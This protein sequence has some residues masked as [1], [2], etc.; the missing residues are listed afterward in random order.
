ML[1]Q[2]IIR[3]KR[4]GEA[5]SREAIDAFVA[6]VVD[7]RASDAQ[8]AAF[9]MAVLLKRMTLDERV[10]LTEAMTRS[11][12]VLDWHAAGFDGPVLDKHSTGGVGDT[13]SLILAPAIA[14]CGAIVP[15]VSGRGLGHTG[16]TLD[17]LESIPGYHAL[18]DGDHLAA[19]LRTAGCAIV[20]ATDDIAPAD[21]RIYAVRDV[22]ATVESIDLITASILSK[23]LAAGLD[24][25]VLDVKTG[26]GA[27]AAGR[28]QADAL[29]ESL[30]TVARGAGLNTRAL[31]TDMGQPLADAAGNAVEVAVAARILA[32]TAWP[33]RLMEVTLAL[34][35][36]LM[37]AGGLADDD[38]DGRARLE[39]ALKDGRAAERFARMVAILGGPDD[40]L[41]RHADYLPEAPI[42]R[43]VHSAQSGVVAAIDTRAIGVAVVALGGGRRRTGDAV[44]PSVGFSAIAALGT[45][46]GPRDRPLA[47]VHA[48]TDA[49]AD[50]A[51]QALAAAITVAGHAEPAPPPVLA[52]LD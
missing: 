18:V 27:F 9:A 28:A 34:G 48:A 31:I 6:G 30:V 11:G 49:A 1:I 17:K 8:I 41:E 23:K 43:P 47:T 26:N 50:E 38:A 46:V 24:A 52:R 3:R 45:P 42:V 12:R 7:K 35:A 25:L 36:T 5:L 13:V 21:R 19:T 33:D 20:G 44:D 51:A 4:D 32:G 16:G 22:T 40:F 15:M 14:A 37:C 39:A 10:A 29:A 2:E